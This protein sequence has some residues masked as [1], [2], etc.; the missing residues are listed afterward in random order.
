MLL[1]HWIFLDVNPP[2]CNQVETVPFRHVSFAEN[3]ETVEFDPAIHGAL[4]PVTE[5]NTSALNMAYRAHAAPA[6]M[7][8]YD[9]VLMM[10]HRAHV[11][12][13]PTVEY[14]ATLMMEHQAHAAPAPVVEYDTASTETHWLCAAPTTVIEYDACAAQ[15]VPSPWW[16][17][18][19]SRSCMSLRCR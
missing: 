18:Q 14:D 11:A 15:A 12:S 13:A 7:V 17:G 10:V 4:S 2:V 6:P 19:S 5:N 16:T 3:V 1:V 9:A 8:E